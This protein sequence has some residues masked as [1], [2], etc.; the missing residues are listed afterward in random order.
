MRLFLTETGTSEKVNAWPIELRYFW[1][2]IW[3]YCDDYGRGADNA[4]LIRA[5]SFPLDDEVT[6]ETV[7]GWM[8]QLERD[9]V[10][11]RYEVAGKRLFSVV[12]WSEH[13]RVQH[14]GKSV[15][16]CPD[17]LIPGAC[18]SHEPFMSPAGES[19]AFVTTPSRDTHPR[20]GSREQGEG[21]G[22]GSAD[23]REGA[24]GPAASKPRGSRIS[25][26]FTITD[27]MRAW[28]TTNAPL[29][30]LDLKLPEFI[31]YWAA[32]PGAKGVKSDWESTWRNSMRKQQEWAANSSA[33]KPAPVDWMN[34]RKRAWW[35][36]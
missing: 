10:I 34:S 36:S 17:H 24:S 33:T 32:V 7:E 9:Q 19:P 15:L 28:A 18:Q 6:V 26:D 8:E 16:P 2:L 22:S 11:R 13:Q 25:R 20:A 5:D 14:P 30:N 3:G 12:N 21:A 1:I 29:V 31:D 27:A 23:E 4:R 35:A